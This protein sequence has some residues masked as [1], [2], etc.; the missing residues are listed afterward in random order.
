MDI[1]DHLAPYA[2]IIIDRH[3]QSKL[4]YD[5]LP[6]NQREF[7]NVNLEKFKIKISDTDWNCIAEINEANEKYICQI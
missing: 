4:Q 7:S 2:N 3:K 6:K 5:F 1:T